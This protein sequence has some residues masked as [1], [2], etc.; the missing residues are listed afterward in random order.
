MVEN[1]DLLTSKK[2]LRSGSE[3]SSP[4][5]NSPESGTH[6]DPNPPSKPANPTNRAHF[7]TVF[8]TDC[9]AYQD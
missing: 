3:I 4:T 8:S 2:S 5:D 1:A 6:T 7:Y 9:T